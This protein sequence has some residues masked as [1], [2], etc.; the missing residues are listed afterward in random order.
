MSN[1]ANN[2]ALSEKVLVLVLPESSKSFSTVFE[3]VK[4]RYRNLEKR[5]VKQIVMVILVASVL[6]VS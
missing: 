3:K 1:A 2:T 4:K 6:L 5:K